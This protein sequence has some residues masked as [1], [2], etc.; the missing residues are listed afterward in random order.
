MPAL[1]E[2]LGDG[3]WEIRS[4]LENKTA[5]VLFTFHE[6]EIV[7]LHG[8]IKRTRKTPVQDLNLARKR[9]RPFKQG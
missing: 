5:R 6:N 2:S 1:V 3:L 4:R 7:L 9:K 8:F